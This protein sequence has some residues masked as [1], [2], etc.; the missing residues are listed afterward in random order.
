M[1]AMQSSTVCWRVTKITGLVMIW[2][3]AVSFDMPPWRMTLRA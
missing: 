2:L 1:I 3:T